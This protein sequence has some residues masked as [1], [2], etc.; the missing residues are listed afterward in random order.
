MSAPRRDRPANDRIAR[1]DDPAPAQSGAWGKIAVGL[2][3]ETSQRLGAIRQ[4]WLAAETRRIEGIIDCAER[5]ARSGDDAD[6]A[7]R[8][9]E[10]QL[11]HLRSLPLGET[12]ALADM[13]RRAES[14]VRNRAASKDFSDSRNA[15]SRS[16]RTP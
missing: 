6:V 13:L 15:R 3:D 5:A 7:L 8:E 10:R 14:L 9:V 1:R 12:D 11:Q 16:A 4:S 2:I